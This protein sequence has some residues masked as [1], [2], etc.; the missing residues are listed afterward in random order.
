MDFGNIIREDVINYCRKK[1]GVDNV[2]R[3]ITFTTLSAKAVCKDVARIMYPD[4]EDKKLGDLISKTIP[5]KPKITLKKCLEES[6]EFVNLYNTNDKVKNIID[7]AL[8]L[9][10]LPKAC[11]QHACGLVISGQQVKNYCPQ[12]ILTDKKTGIPAPT[13]QYTMGTVEE[14][15]LLKM[16]FLGLKTMTVLDENVKDINEVYEK[17]MKIDDIPINDPLTYENIAKGKTVGVFQLE[18]SGMTSFMTKLFQD[19]TKKINEINKKHLSKEDKEIEYA[20]LGNVL[21][22]RLI[23]G[24][25]LYR[26]GPMDE[27][28]RYIDGML[29]PTHIVYDTPELENILNVTYGV[30]VY[31]E[32]VMTAVRELAKF[33]R[34]QADTIRK[35][36]GKKLT[37]I[38]DEFKEYFIYGSGT[39]LDSKTGKLIDIKGCVANGISEKKATIIW[40]KMYE[41][42]KYAF[43][44]SHAGGYAVVGIRTGWVNTHYPVIFM[45]ANLNTYIDNNDKLKPYLAH[46]YKE[47]IKVLPP[48]VNESKQLFTVQGIE[49]GIRYGLR[50]LSKIKSLSDLIFDERELR[51]KFKSF[52]DFVERMVAYQK[53]NTGQME[54]LIFAGALDEFEGTR[55]AK[56]FV[57]NKMMGLAKAS[58]KNIQS[59]QITL[60]DFAEENGIEEIAEMKNVPIPDLEEYDKD[61]LLSKEKEY[62]G[63]YITGHP[64]DDFKD[65]LKEQ[66]II[67]ISELTATV[68]NDNY[69]EEFV[70]DTDE[71]NDSDEVELFGEEIVND[72]NPYLG[73]TVSVSGII[74]EVVPRYGRNNKMFLTFTIEDRTGELSFICFNNKLAK[75]QEKILKDKKVIIKGKFDVND[76]GAQIIVDTVFD[77][78]RDVDFGEKIT[79]IGSNDLITARNQWKNL[80]DLIKRKSEFQGDTKV[81]FIRDDK[82]Y[83]LPNG[84]NLNLFTLSKLQTMFGKENCKPNNEPKIS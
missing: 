54:S 35:S 78:E 73:E 46:C 49:D 45:K 42:S 9:E 15:G 74:T 27:I 76:F 61:Y 8:R 47:G 19:V 64:L 63:S 4:Q 56:V 20:K 6:P 60:F 50:G 21:F 29:N 66:N 58:K 2:S 31:Q 26:P 32:Q 17:N 70:S 44:K 55:R 13:T 28:P 69:E 14:L 16:D 34:G 11:S 10:G 38:L 7:N 84:I 37:E 22:E 72:E 18:S 57:I 62:A 33:N 82:K 30:I 36:M 43:N 71:N 65:F 51:G 48:S 41:F 77:L 83:L 80:T 53:L 67:E 5:K 25:S 59:G 24:I 68:S 1:Y 39:K 40:D 23:A 79:L 12:V 75:N 81:I 3:I 52:Q